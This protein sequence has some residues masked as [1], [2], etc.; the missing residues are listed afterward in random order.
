MNKSERLSIRVKNPRI[1][2]VG[3]THFPF[4]DKDKAAAVVKLAKEL[5]PN[6]VIQIG[7]LFDLYTFSRFARS[8]NF[9]TPVEEIKQGRKMAGEFWEQLQESSPSAQCFQLRG[10]HSARIV[11]N[12]MAKAPE[13]EA[14]LSSSIDALTEFPGVK[15]MKSHRSEIEVNGILFIH[16]WSTRLGHHMNYFGQSVV[17]GHTHHGGLLYRS[18][19]PKPL[20]ELNCGFIADINALPLEYGETKTNSW[21]AGVGFIDQLGPRFIAL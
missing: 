7:D 8:V 19:I 1:L 20:F 5:K 10:N 3:D 12:L 9:I 21:V 18:G 16:G 13:Y 2:A 14:L 15:D 11:K 17:C 4:V 6:A